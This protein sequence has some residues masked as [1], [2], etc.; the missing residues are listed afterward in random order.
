[1]NHLLD[2][3]VWYMDDSTRIFSANN[4]NMKIITGDL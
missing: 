1:M 3:Y 2:R 4:E